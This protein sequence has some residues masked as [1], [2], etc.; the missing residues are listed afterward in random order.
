MA[1]IVAGAIVIGFAVGEPRVTW[2]VLLGG[3]TLW[4]GALL[5]AVTIV[6]EKS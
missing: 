3:I 1:N 5:F 4:A 6:E 2:P